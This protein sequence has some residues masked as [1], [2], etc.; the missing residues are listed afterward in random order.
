M[1]LSP[2]ASASDQ[3]VRWAIT[4][5]EDLT[6]ADGTGLFIEVVE[7]AFAES[8]ITVERIYMPWRRALHTVEQG[9]ADFAGG[10]ERTDKFLQSRYPINEIIESA[11]FHENTI[12]DWS[13]MESLRNLRG[14]WA[15]GYLDAFPASI[16]PLLT[17]EDVPRA[18]AL[19]MVIQGRADYY[20]DNL[21]Q[22]RKTLARAEQSGS[23]QA[24]MTHYRIETIMQ[25]PLYL[26]FTHGDRGAEIK[27]AY[28]DGIEALLRSG[29]LEQIYQKWGINMPTMEGH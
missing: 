19:Q 28:D 8:G 25:V 15:I 1:L 21:L 2:W 5:W 17:G 14:A 13:G 22:M 16:R 20:L 10:L 26:S 3:T 12:P 7:Q 29:Q 24:N 11:F 23:I 18:S 9:D 27:Q 4:E 6:N